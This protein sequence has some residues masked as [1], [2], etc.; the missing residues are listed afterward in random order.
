[1][2][3]GWVNIYEALN[4]ICCGLVTVVAVTTLVNVCLCLA[5]PNSSL[6]DKDF[7]ARSLLGK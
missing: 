7:G 4:P 6:L 3:I 5:F 2:G 1:M